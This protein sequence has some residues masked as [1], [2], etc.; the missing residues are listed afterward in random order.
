M[1]ARCIYSRRFPFNFLS[2]DSSFIRASPT[3]STFSPPL[4]FHK[5]IHLFILSLPRSH[6]TAC[7]GWVTAPRTS[8]LEQPPSGA[9]P[10]PAAHT[11]APKAPSCPRHSTAAL[12]PSPCTSASSPAL[13]RQPPRALREA[14]GQRA[15]GARGHGP[16]TWPLPQ[17]AGRG[18]G[19]WGAAGRGADPPSRSDRAPRS[20]AVAAGRPGAGGHRGGKDRVSRV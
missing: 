14:G 9:K 3:I 1:P 13:R 6:C 18:V 20:P 10:R 7:G 2:L 8:R 4:L 11:P 16:G 12:R 15:S 5:A 19:A 17:A